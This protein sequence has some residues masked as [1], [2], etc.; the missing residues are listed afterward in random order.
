MVILW[1]MSYVL[2][3]PC[4]RPSIQI[5]EQYIRKQ[6]GVHLSG[7]QMVGLPG[8]QMAFEN[9]NIWHQPLLDHSK[10]I[11]VWYSDP[12][13][14]TNTVG[15]WNPDT[16]ESWMVKKWKDA[17]WSRFWTTNEFWTAWQIK[18]RPNGHHLGCLCTGLVFKWL[19]YV[20][21][22]QFENIP[23]K[24]FAFHASG[25]GLVG[26]Q[27]PIV[28]LAGFVRGAWVPITKL[29]GVDFIKGFAPCA[30]LL[31]LAPNFCAS[32]KLLK[33]WVQGAKV[34]RRGAK[35]F[36]KSTPSRTDIKLR[37]E[38]GKRNTVRIW[39]PTI[40]NMDFLKVGFQMVPM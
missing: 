39:N 21:D 29:S 26:F 9:Q 32:K 13:C 11:L 18:N 28:W 34:G 14:K 15:I 1:V 10:T 35:L 33:S 37:D 4:S 25:F 31:R 22:R 40:W 19:V 6:D 20:L 30:H 27:I 7:I 16:F 24:N 23:L 12:H 36:I 8:I 3:R 17:K 38:F 2:D 5:P